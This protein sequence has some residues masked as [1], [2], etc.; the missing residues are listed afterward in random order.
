V[1]CRAR[2]AARIERRGSF[3]REREPS[4]KHGALLNRKGVVTE[5]QPGRD[6]H[7]KVLSVAPL[8]KEEAVK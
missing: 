5:F 6:S 3:A 1:K 4:P 8:N 7:E 2:P